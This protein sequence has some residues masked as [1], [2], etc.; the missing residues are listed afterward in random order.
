MAGSNHNRMNAASRVYARALL[1]MAVEAGQ[2]EMVLDQMNQI[3]G[4]LA[5]DGGFQKLLD[6]RALPKAERAGVIERVL[7]PRV[8]E[9]LFR[10]F[11]VINRKD[12][13]SEL[14]GIITAL[15]LLYRE[16]QGV[17]DVSVT[18]ASEPDDAAKDHLK[19]RLE[20]S[21][22]R[23]VALTTH[24]DPSLLGGMVTRIGDRQIDTS[25]VGRLRRLQN[26]MIDAGRAKARQTVNA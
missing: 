14:P 26:Q 17:A 4:L 7:K 2:A 24:V 8:H 5:S 15:N 16:S 25:V 22:G 12:R 21:L 23:Q 20:E 9:L 11:Q 10:F 3:G 18:L 1:E 13:L 6:P 19:K